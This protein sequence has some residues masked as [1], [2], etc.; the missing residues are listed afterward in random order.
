MAGNSSL[1]CRRRRHRLVPTTRCRRS[2]PPER[3]DLPAS[4]RSAR[5]CFGWV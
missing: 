5:A 1:T 2:R 3:P 4:C